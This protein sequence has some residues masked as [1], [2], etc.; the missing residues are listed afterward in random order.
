[1]GWRIAFFGAIITC[2]VNAIPRKATPFL[3]LLQLH[4]QNDG[5]GDRQGRY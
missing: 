3:A 1:M 4:R 2:T 5:D